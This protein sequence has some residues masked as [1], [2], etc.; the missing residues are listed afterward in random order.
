[1]EF[2]DM[3]T[4][5]EFRN[6]TKEALHNYR[7]AFRLEKQAA[8]Y[9]KNENIGEPSISILFRSAAAIA[10]RAQ[11]ETE[12]I[13]LA[14]LGL[15]N[16]T[17]DEIRAE[18]EKIIAAAKRKGFGR[19]RQMQDT[20]INEFF[21]IGKDGSNIE[22][23]ITAFE[24]GYASENIEGAISILQRLLDEKPNNL[25][26]VF[27]CEGQFGFDAIRKFCQFTK[28]QRSLSSIPF[29]VEG[30]SLPDKET[31]RYWKETLIDEILSLHQLDSHA[32]TWKLE[33]L[34]KTKLNLSKLSHVYEKQQE[35][36]LLTTRT[37]GHHYIK[38]FI[39][40]LLALLALTILFPVF[41]LIALAIRLESNGPIFYIAKRAGRGY[42]IFN[43]YKFRTMEVNA[44]KK[45]DA[46]SDL[47]QN[48]PSQPSPVFYKLTNDPRI[49]K[50]GSFLRKYS[51]DELP[52]F[53]NVLRGDMSIV[54][55]RPLPLYEAQTLTTDEWA[56]RFMAPAGITGLWQIKKR[57]NMSVEERVNLDIEY[58]KKN[59][60]MYDLWIMAN[61]PSSLLQKNDDF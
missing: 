29:V 22:R 32:I 28:S 58:A 56:A 43:F 53:W 44:D 38:R 7:I 45:I 8:L 6:E 25:P 12:A 54:G 39:D 1:M 20:I 21:Y 15:S 26:D 19:F 60:F 2:F 59:T 48:T 31:A 24:C 5:Q 42:R 46:L 35:P 18:L 13:E 61:T 17:P 40:I 51:L 10:M 11:L 57:G 9:A 4:V 14:K 47:I 34:K 52:Q 49:T 37:P 55:N 16:G 36:Y 41:I 27:I 23:L 50:V 3:A 30:S 33:F